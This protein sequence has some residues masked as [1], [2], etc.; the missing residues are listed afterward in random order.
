MKKRLAF[1]VFPFL[2]SA[3]IDWSV[4]PQPFPVWTT[5]PTRTPGIVTATPVI[6]FGTVTSLPFTLTPGMVTITPMP[7]TLTPGTVTTTPSETPTITS[8]DTP[9][10][11]V[12]PV[13]F[14]AVEVTILGCN[15]SIDITQGMGEVTN[16][17]VI[18]KNTGN[19]DLPNTCALL[20]AIDEGREH[21]DKKRCVDNLP[22]GN[23][24][25]QKLTVDSTYKQNT[26][27]QVDVSSNDV[28]L[29]RVDKQS[30]TDISLSGGAPSDVGVI[31]PITP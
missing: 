23:Q 19:T 12:T 8:S 30:C 31:K 5:I 21:P 7:F 16:T 20:R 13:P 25:T 15:T 3:C 17:Y 24:V 2:L 18:V 28:L 4:N 29:K 9:T 26:I 22:V 14:Q 1:I 11:T 6:I 10:L 27:I